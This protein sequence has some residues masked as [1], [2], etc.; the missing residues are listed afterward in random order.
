MEE[1]DGEE[2]EEEEEEGGEE[3]GVHWLGS[4]GGVGGEVGRAGGEWRLLGL[5]AEARR[6]GWGLRGMVLGGL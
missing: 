1:G 2:G 3:E 4:G 5:G 6:A